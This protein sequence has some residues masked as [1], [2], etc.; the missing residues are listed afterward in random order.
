MIFPDIL[1]P[2]EG[3]ILEQ[4]V[5]ISET[6]MSIPCLTL[7]TGF[8]TCD[9][10]FSALRNLLLWNY[11]L[12]VEISITLKGRKKFIFAFVLFSYFFRLFICLFLN[13]LINSQVKHKR[14]SRET[15]WH[16]YFFDNICM[17]SLKHISE[18]FPTILESPV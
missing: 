9:Y 18:I 14:R 2:Q 13:G 17:I 12:R 11:L 4:K 8:V 7:T 5:N 15:S 6:W 1:L 10:L 16:P 3:K